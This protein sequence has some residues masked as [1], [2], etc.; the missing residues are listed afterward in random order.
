M[1]VLARRSIGGSFGRRARWRRFLQLLCGTVP[2]ES[3]VWNGS[4]GRA[5]TEVADAVLSVR[6]DWPGRDEL[7]RRVCRSVGG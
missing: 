6:S 1:D 2:V 3:L 7:L 4:Y 5:R